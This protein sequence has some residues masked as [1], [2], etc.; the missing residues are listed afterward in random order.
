L[1]PIVVEQTGRGERAYDIYS[2]LLKD[3]IIFLG[4]P[5]DDNI[6]N[7]VIAQMLFLEAEDPNKDVFLYINSPGG[8]VTSGMAIYDTM[9]F[10]RPHVSTMCVGQAASMG[11]LLLAGGAE[12]GVGE[13]L[14]PLFRQRRLASAAKPGLQP[15]PALVIVD[16]RERQANRPA[17]AAAQSRGGVA[18]QLMQEFVIRVLL[19]LQHANS[20]EPDSQV[21]QTTDLALS[22]GGAEEFNVFSDILYD[23]SFFLPVREKFFKYHD[24]P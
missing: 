22:A 12:P 11:A 4:T 2:R 13:Q 5:I 9:Q 17:V 8:S 18:K 6:A 16:D 15:G 24:S 21:H 23:L 14:E 10:V 1:I 7:V 3:R 20:A 19:P